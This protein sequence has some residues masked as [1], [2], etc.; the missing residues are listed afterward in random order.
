MTL[1]LQTTPRLERRRV[2]INKW[3]ATLNG[4]AAQMLYNAKAN[5]RR[6]GV[7]C[8][9]T[10]DWI[11]ERLVRGTCEVT[12]IPFDIRGQT[13]TQQPWAPS[14]DRQDNN[15]GYTVD[16]VRV[17]CWMYNRA[18]GVYTDADVQR[19]A[20]ATLYPETA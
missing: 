9:L 6:L 12:G 10:R 11:K 14:L 1:S 2:T 19:L 5:A 16:N 8:A 18:K 4:R 7:E 20:R 13:K 15:A 17:V 3:H